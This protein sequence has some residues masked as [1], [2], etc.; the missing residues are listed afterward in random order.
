[1]DV[2]NFLQSL[3][4]PCMPSLNCPPLLPPSVQTA[5]TGS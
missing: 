3:I 1:L 4:L 2:V 5:N